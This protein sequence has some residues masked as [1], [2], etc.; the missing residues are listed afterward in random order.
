MGTI[1]QLNLQLLTNDARLESLGTML[2]ELHTAASEGSLQGLTPLNP[3]ELVSW[4][5]ELIYT[6]QE[7]IVEIEEHRAE[8][9]GLYLVK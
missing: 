3:T 8:P 9:A 5:R 4:L 1:Q 2:D 6:A 7:T